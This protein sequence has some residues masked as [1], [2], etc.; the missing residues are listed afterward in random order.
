MKELVLAHS[1]GGNGPQ[2]EALVLAIAVLGMAIAGY[3]Q[4]TFKPIWSAG[5]GVVGIG[6]SV[7]AFTLSGSNTTTAPANVSVSIAKPSKGAT[8]PANVPV[9]IEAEIAG[10]T[11]TD[12]T[13]GTDPTKGHIHIFVDGELSSMPSKLVTP[14]ELETGAHEITVE[15]VAADH[16]QFEPRILDTVEVTAE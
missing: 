16:S 7:L 2:L 6:F 13:T 5:L 9:D 3:R 12:E 11:L 8:V 14:V 1:M 4:K 10:E 15:F